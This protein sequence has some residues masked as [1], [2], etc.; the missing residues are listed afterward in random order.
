MPRCTA[1]PPDRRRPGSDLHARLRSDRPQKTPT[2][3]SRCRDDVR[4]CEAPRVRESSAR[5]MA[6]VF[7]AAERRSPRWF[8]QTRRLGTRLECCRRCS[9]A[10]IGPASPPAAGPSWPTPAKLSR[11]PRSRTRFRIP[12]RRATRA[13]RGANS[14][15]PDS[16]ATAQTRDAVSIGRIEFEAQSP[17]RASGAAIGP[18]HRERSNVPKTRRPM[19]R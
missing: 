18:I 7:A 6:G 5:S 4:S 3:Q 1:R 14:R 19:P 15:T 16:S 2:R 11:V 8:R 17:R 12:D 13:N 10:I 9:G